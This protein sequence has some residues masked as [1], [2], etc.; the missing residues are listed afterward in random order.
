MNAAKLSAV[1]AVLVTAVVLMLV[2]E[3][4]RNRTLQEQNMALR[5]Q[6]SETF[7]KSGQA[8]A[9]GDGSG[10]STSSAP[11]ERALSLG[12]EVERLRRENVELGQLL[13]RQAA[14]KSNSLSAAAFEPSSTWSD[15]GNASPEAA[16]STFAWAITAGDERRLLDVG[17]FSEQNSNEASGARIVEVLRP[18]FSQVEASRLVFSDNTSP[19]EVTFWFQS[20][21]RGGKTLVSPMVVKQVGD[22]WKVTMVSDAP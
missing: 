8:D 22:G 13:V 18:L 16:A 10:E 9:V 12:K 1:W 11:P 21:L 19:G 15:V 4:Q 5:G 14:A 2:L 3:R 17:I 20:R 7:N 6:P